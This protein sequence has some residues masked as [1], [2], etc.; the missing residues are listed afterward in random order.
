MGGLLDTRCH[1]SRIA[2]RCVIH[3]KVASN[4]SHDDQTRVDT[5]SHLKIDPTAMLDFFLITLQGLLDPERRMDGP[6]RMVLM[7]DW[8]AKEGHDAVT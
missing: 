1:V 6:L 2:D 8:R 3:S 5:L 4:A 7:R